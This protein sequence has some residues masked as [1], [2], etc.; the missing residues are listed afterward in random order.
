MKTEKEELTAAEEAELAE[1]L[2]ELVERLEEEIALL[3][4]AGPIDQTALNDLLDRRVA[5]VKEYQ[6]ARI[7]ADRPRVA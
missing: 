7:A 6:E 2:R 1:E 3:C 4:S 5:A